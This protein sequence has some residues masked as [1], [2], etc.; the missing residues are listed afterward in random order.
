VARRLPEF[1]RLW[2]AYPHGSPEQVKSQIGG[3]ANY[4]WIVNTCTIRIS[5]SFNYAG[6]PVPATD[7][8]LNT[9]RGSDGLRYAYRVKEFKRYLTRVYGLARL[10][11]EY[12]SAGGDV[13]E[14][15]RGRKGV[16]AFDVD[17]WSD[18]TGHIDLWNG[19]LCAGQSYFD[20]AAQVYLWEAP[21][22]SH[23]AITE[24]VGAGGSNRS[25]DIRVVQDLLR[26]NGVDPGPSDGVY[27][28]TT[29]RAIRQFQ[30]RLFAKPDG[31]VDVGGYTWSRL[32][33][34]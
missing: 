9:V 5:R 31:R 28:P 18:A 4:D 2:A 1:S 24:S 19:E 11:Q 30:R 6:H 8:A 32:L 27:G 10:T 12:E 13:P 21:E 7:P 17:G 29:L 26:L 23:L 3:G 33:E 14:S 16:I 22:L 15:F 34:G 20:K 25:E